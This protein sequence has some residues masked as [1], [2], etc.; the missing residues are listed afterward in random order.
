MGDTANSV[1]VMSSCFGMI[2][3]YFHVLNAD[4]KIVSIQIID[5]PQ[6]NN[7]YTFPRTMA[8][9]VRWQGLVD[10]MKVGITL[11]NSELKGIIGQRKKEELNDTEKENVSMKEEMRK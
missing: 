1:D 6:R 2:Q 3:F 4:E 9:I 7:N 5:K 10:K 11:L 8:N